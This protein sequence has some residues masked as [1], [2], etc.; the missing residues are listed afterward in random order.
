M[1]FNKKIILFSFVFILFANLA[2]A[3]GNSNGNGFDMSESM[4]GVSQIVV[5][6]FKF[7]LGE[8]LNDLDKTFFA[9]GFIFIGMFALLMDLFKNKLK[10]ARNTSVILGLTVGFMSVAFI[11]ETLV[12]IIVS[13][14]A[15]V[16]SVFLFMLPL[17]A[18]YKLSE[19]FKDRPMLR[20][21]LLLVM[22]GLLIF[23]GNSLKE[24]TEGNAF[25]SGSINVLMPVLLCLIVGILLNST[26]KGLVANSASKVPFLGKP[27]KAILGKGKDETSEEQNDKKEKNNEIKAIKETIKRETD[28]AKELVKGF[29]NQERVL[30]SLDSAIST[31]QKAIED[32]FI[33]EKERKKLRDQIIAVFDAIKK[34]DYV[35]S[36]LDQ[37]LDTNVN[38]LRALEQSAIKDFNYDVERFALYDEFEKRFHKNDGVKLYLSSKNFKDNFYNVL[39]KIHF[40]KVEEYKN[41]IDEHSIKMDEVEKDYSGRKQVMVLIDRARSSFESQTNVQ[42]IKETFQEIKQIVIALK[43]SLG[44]HTKRINKSAEHIL[45]EIDDDYKDYEHL[46]DE[47][48]RNEN[49]QYDNW[50]ERLLTSVHQSDFNLNNYF[51]D[52][53]YGNVGLIQQKIVSS[54]QSEDKSE[55][56]E[57]LDELHKLFKNGSSKMFPIVIDSDVEK[58]AKQYHDDIERATS[59][60]TRGTKALGKAERQNSKAE[61][62]LNDALTEEDES[63]DKE[64]LADNED[65]SLFDKAK[66][67]LHTKIGD[68]IS[69]KVFELSSQMGVEVKELEENIKK[70]QTKE[71]EDKKNIIL[72]YLINFKNMKQEEFENWLETQRLDESSKREL[73]LAFTNDKVSSDEEI[74]ITILP[75]LVREQKVKDK[76]KKQLSKLQIAGR[77]AAGTLILSLA[78]GG[79]LWFV[80]RGKDEKPKEPTRQEIVVDENGQAQNPTDTLN[81]VTPETPD[82]LSG[83]NNIPSGDTNLTDNADG[84]NW[85]NYMIQNF[86]VLKSSG[87][88]GS[89]KDNMIIDSTTFAK[90]LETKDPEKIKAFIGK[91]AKRLEDLIDA[92]KPLK[93]EGMEIT[94]QDYSDALKKGNF[95]PILKRIK[96]RNYKK[97]SKI[98]IPGANLT[99]TVDDLINTTKLDLQFAKL[100]VKYENIGNI[101]IGEAGKKL[102]EYMKALPETAKELKRQGKMED[103]FTILERLKVNITEAI[104]KHA[105][106]NNNQTGTGE[107]NP[108]EEVREEETQ[109]K[110]D[111]IQKLNTDNQKFIQSEFAKSTQ[112]LIDNRA[113]NNYN[114]SFT[115]SY[116]SALFKNY[117]QSLGF[118]NGNRKVGRY[119]KN[120]NQG[121]MSFDKALDAL[122][123]LQP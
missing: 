54:K 106:A 99:I 24:A 7:F 39:E 110:I 107:S 91:G 66:E 64:V 9:K 72:E 120:I 81:N 45:K 98:T 37:K 14:Y 96:D 61:D 44:E 1:K 111:L 41:L 80:N 79:Y 51:Y 4:K 52:D 21:L 94:Q 95:K 113:T 97:K 123:K 20:V 76:I 108:A 73:K 23:F 78:V 116:N 50:Y 47:F 48:Y 16:A 33:K 117:A 3:P 115:N 30:N 89:V 15:A 57:V 10:L 93:N 2:F 32:P 86:S 58:R 121:K 40:E 77:V 88:R 19:N 119:I 104:T 22:L 8:H 13:E 29:D 46:F 31:Y 82:T 70:L 62:D 43:N 18:T 63:L 17:Y 6:T 101:Q 26:S 83:E 34:E 109:E 102:K 25:L 5:D 118:T 35:N 69:D 53:S 12:N 114:A 84:T 87:N 27:L 75:I 55:F 65:I 85:D 105:A 74:I 28:Y 122:D 60:E 71:Y 67:K 11:P 100:A 59:L 92:V 90:Q 38:N 112:Q 36:V 56:V 42:Y 68:E 49:S 103:V